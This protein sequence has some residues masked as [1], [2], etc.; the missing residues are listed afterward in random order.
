MV[1]TLLGIQILA[2]LFACF[3]LYV[4]FVH[5]KQRNI[6]RFEMLFWAG[7]WGAFL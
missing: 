1:E 2:G 7:V 5:F 4:A 6:E 3:M